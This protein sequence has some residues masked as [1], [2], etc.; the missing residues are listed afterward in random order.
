MDGHLPASKAR[1]AE[2]TAASTSSRVA[3]ATRAIVAPVAGLG[4]SYVPPSEA[5]RQSPPIRSC[6]FAI[7]EVVLIRAAFLLDPLEYRCDALPHTDAHRRET[8]TPPAPTQFVE[9]RRYDARAARPER[10]P[11]RNRSA[12]GVGRAGIET[13]VAHARNR[14]RG[15]RLV[16]F[17][18]VEL[19]DSDA[20]ARQRGARSRNRP[21]PHDVRSNARRRTAEQPGHRREPQTPR[22][23]R[24]AEEDGR[25]A[26]VDARRVARRDGAAGF[27]GRIQLPAAREGRFRP[28]VLVRRDEALVSPSVSYRNAYQLVGER[29][30]FHRRLTLHL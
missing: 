24:F 13:D 19:G 12:V 8:V 6:V 5:S 7:T 25:R 10:M 11:E 16:D 20:G 22:R 17:R 2:A 15:K 18:H 27:K 26:V 29:A 23:L 14:L 1:R 3:S 9:Q 30:A 4:S 28:G 21:Q